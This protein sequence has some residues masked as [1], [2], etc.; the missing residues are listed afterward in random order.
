MALEKPSAEQSRSPPWRSSFGA[1]AM[2]CTRLSSFP[3][4]V[5]MRSNTASSCPGTLT[6]SGAVMVAP[7]SL[8]SGST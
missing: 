7:T 5:R 3:H 8:A 6:S 2:E 4:R 1:K